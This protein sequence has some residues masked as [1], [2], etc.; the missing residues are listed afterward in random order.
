[1]KWYVPGP[2]HYL[3]QKAVTSSCGEDLEL[4]VFLVL[5]LF[6]QRLDLEF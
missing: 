3:R 6:R 5:C 4:Q 2:R 1:M